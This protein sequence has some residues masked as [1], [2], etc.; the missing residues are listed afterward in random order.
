MSRLSK[1]LFLGLIFF[2][3]CNPT[4]VQPSLLEGTIAGLSYRYQFGKAQPVV[5]T[6]L[7]DSK[8]FGEDQVEEDPCLINFSSRGYISIQLPF[9]EGLPSTPEVSLSSIY[10]LQMKVTPLLGFIDTVLIGC[11][12]AYM[13]VDYDSINWVE[14]TFILDKCY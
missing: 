7:Y 3:H 6:D 9:K 10:Q 13:E 8:L 14:G 4:N 2:H 11:M 12:N 5:N 1:A